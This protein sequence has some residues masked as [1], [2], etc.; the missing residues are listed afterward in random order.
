MGT[1]EERPDGPA[2][3]DRV[4]WIVLGVLAVGGIVLA[5]LSL[6]SQPQMGADEDVFRTVDALFTAVT[7]RDEQRLGQCEQQLRAY[8]EAGKLPPEAAAALDS[9]IRSARS[10]RWE[11]AA[12]RLYD[13]MRDQRRDGA[14]HHPP[15]KTD[16]AKTGK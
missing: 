1:T 13:F 9:V 2:S 8:Q 6:R 7:S 15:K 5:I 10:G 16:R 11:S 4:A 3:R 12:E 14:T